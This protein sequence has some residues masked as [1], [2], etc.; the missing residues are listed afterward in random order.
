M[1]TQTLI[2]AFLTAVIVSGVQAQSAGPKLYRWVDKEGKVHYGDALPADAVDQARDEFSATT[3]NRLASVPR[4][5]TA[6]ERAKAAADQTA[7]T[8][9]A[10]NAREQDRVEKAM[11][12]NY[13]TEAELVHAYSERLKLLKSSLASATVSLK[14]M[15]SNLANLLDN[16]SE[17]EL[18]HRKVIAKKAGAIINLHKELTL[19]ETLWTSNQIEYSS[20]DAEYQRALARYRELR[21]KTPATTTTN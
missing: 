9:A 12:A 21:S 17:I 3:G 13:G 8:L 19:Q 2:V 7:A 5:L 15:R 4:A 16:A 18:G 6:E 11:M 1:K 10:V 14:V 20:L